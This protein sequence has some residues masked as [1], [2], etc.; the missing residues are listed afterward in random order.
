MVKRAKG[1]VQSK[2]NKD[3]LEATQPSEGVTQ[4]LRRVMQ[5]HAEAAQH[6]HEKSLKFIKRKVYE[7]GGLKPRSGRGRF[8]QS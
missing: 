4:S 7:P 8:T 2:G 6:L 3:T 1:T 5:A